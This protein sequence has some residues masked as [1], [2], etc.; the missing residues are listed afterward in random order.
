M[1]VDALDDEVEGL[2]QDVDAGRPAIGASAWRA[3]SAAVSACARV[4]STPWTADTSPW[5]GR[6]R[7][8]RPCPS[9][10]DRRSRRGGRLRSGRRAPDGSR[11]PRA[12][13]R[14]RGAASAASA[15]S[16]Q[17]ADRSAA[18]L[19]RW[20]A[21]S[22]AGS[23]VVRSARRSS[24]CPPPCPS[25][26]AA[27]ASRRTS[28]G[29]RSAMAGSIAAASASDRKARCWS[30]ARQPRRPARRRRGAWWEPAPKGIV[31]HTGQ[32]V[33]EERVRVNELDRRGDG[34]DGLRPRRPR[35]GTRLR[36]GVAARASA[37]AQRVEAVA[38]PIGSPSRP[39]ARSSAASIW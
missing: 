23:G 36:S 17:A 18:V 1:S 2:Q 30:A 34:I 35:R 11:S 10:R 19:A 15:P 25:A 29:R 27:V 5:R 6:R 26:P 24:S 31:V 32:V 22:P 38:A 7:P 9:G 3:R 37:C 13:R 33:V 28:A 39:T 16:A 14:S 20:I 12:R 4:P 21:S 8:R